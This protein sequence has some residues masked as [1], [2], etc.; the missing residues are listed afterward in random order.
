MNFTCYNLI[1]TQNR[2]FEETKTKTITDE[3]DKIADDSATTTETTPMAI[4]IAE[5]LDIANRMSVRGFS[6]KPQ[7]SI[8]I[9]GKGDSVEADEPVGDGKAEAPK[10]CMRACESCSI[11]TCTENNTIIVLQSHF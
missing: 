6:A 10:V 9:V 1:L 7:I 8:K 4:P 5:A 3:G 2:K 11:N